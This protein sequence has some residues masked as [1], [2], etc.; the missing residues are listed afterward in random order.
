MYFYLTTFWGDVPWVGEVIQPEDAY[1]ER[2]PRE[3]VIDQLVE[4][5]K[6]AA[7]RMP[8]E[9]YTG[10]KL[11]RRR[12]LGRFSYIGT[13]CLAKRK[14]GTGCKNEVNISSKTVPMACMNTKN[15]FNHEGDDRE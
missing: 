9:R 13:Y 2:T 14:M 11:G 8:E 10:D 5:L 7:E 4:D 15:Y 1:I 12:P 6:W 3:K